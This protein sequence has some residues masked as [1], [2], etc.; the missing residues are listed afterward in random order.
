MLGFGVELRESYRGKLLSSRLL[1]RIG[2][3][4]VMG[5][6]HVAG[7]GREDDV[8]SWV[9]TWSRHVWSCVSMSAIFDWAV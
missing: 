5:V 4:A 6:S 3:L 2:L 8:G 9:G 1:R 7:E